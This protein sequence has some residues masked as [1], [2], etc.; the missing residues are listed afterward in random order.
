MSD[1]KP[2]LVKSRTNSFA[3]KLGF[4]SARPRSDLKEPNADPFPGI[5]LKETQHTGFSSSLAIEPE[6]PRLSAAEK[7]DSPVP[8]S[9]SSLTDSAPNSPVP[10][11]RFPSTPPPSDAPRPKPPPP[12]AGPKPTLRGSPTPRPRAG[13]G[14]MTPRGGSDDSSILN[15]TLTIHLVANELFRSCNFDGPSRTASLSPDTTPQDV[16]EHLLGSFS[17]EQAASYRA[18]ALSSLYLSNPE[19]TLDASPLPFNLRLFDSDA[20]TY[21]YGVELS[22]IHI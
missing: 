2:P 9:S 12:P 13:S 19:E 7:F 20:S 6:S 14:I 22:L 10:S 16:V 5:I 18:R 1:D 8:F 3:H 4:R 17:S 11:L 21:W 15:R